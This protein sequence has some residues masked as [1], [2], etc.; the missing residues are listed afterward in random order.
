VAGSPLP[1]TLAAL[2]TSAVPD[3]DVV[4]IS[5]ARLAADFTYAIAVDHLDRR[6]VIRLPNDAQ[7]GA[8]QE[9]EI[10]LLKALASHS[11]A[12]RLPFEVPRPRGAVSTPDGR[13]VLVYAQLPGTPLNLEA[14]EPGPGTAMSLGRTIAALHQLP[15][16]L[17]ESVGMPIYTPGQYRLR[18]RS[19][20]DEAARTGYLTDRLV[21]RWRLA[22][23]DDRR[24][25]FQ[26]SVIHG[27]MAADHLL[28]QHGRICAMLDFA[29]VQFSDPAEDLAPL[30]AGAAPAVGESIMDAYRANRPGFNDDALE[31]RARLLT[32]LAVI[33]WL[34]YGV[35]QRDEAVIADARVMIADLDQAVEEEDRELERLQ[36]EAQRRDNQA[37]QRKA[38]VERASRRAEQEAAQRT[39]TFER[40][41]VRE[42]MPDSA[43]P[44]AAQNLAL[45]QAAPSASRVPTW[46]GMAAP[47]PAEDLTSSNY[48]P[49]AGTD[50]AS[51]TE[52]LPQALAAR[53]D[54][55]AESANELT[56]QV[57]LPV[58]PAAPA[59]AEP[60]QLS[61]N[62]PDVAATDPAPADPPA[63]TPPAKGHRRGPHRRSIAEGGVGIWGRPKRQIPTWED[64]EVI[65]SPED[66]PPPNPPVED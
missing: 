21:D 37:A 18:L 16:E 33:R 28:E 39:G 1:Y 59:P 41:I 31:E 32:E 47:E 57:P 17:V 40:L 13:R 7:A 52:A 29:T 61:T 22:I 3:I 36:E 4:A 65:N 27:D 26:P 58:M 30:L 55:P 35:R 54:S 63:A 56:A 9:A 45:E 20:V 8:G 66:I 50:D 62:S 34:L 6:W 43:Q 12:G 48:R 46:P 5:P 11:S 49:A 42:V 2:A 64:A 15:K 44:A 53:D 51:P 10:A 38:A 25:S 60:A 23:E 14:I 24:W 19:E